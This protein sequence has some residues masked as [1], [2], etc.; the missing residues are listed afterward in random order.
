MNYANNSFKQTIFIFL[1]NARDTDP[2]N[3]VVEWLTLL[4]I[5]EVP[6]SNIGSDNGYCEVSMVFLSPS[7]WRYSA[8]KSGDDRFL[9]NSFHFIIQLSPFH[10]TQNSHNYRYSVDKKNT[11]K[12][13]LGVGLSYNKIYFLSIGH[14]SILCAIRTFAAYLTLRKSINLALWC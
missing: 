6:G 10:S 5:R 1:R 12:Q 3:I 11:N 2:P 9:S 4:R 13:F 7:K 14:V 8:L